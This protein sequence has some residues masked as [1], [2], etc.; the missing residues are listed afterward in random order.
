MK[1]LM[2]VPQSVKHRMFWAHLVTVRRQN[3]L[4]FVLAWKTLKNKAQFY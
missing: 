4:L 3:Q 2:L 1:G